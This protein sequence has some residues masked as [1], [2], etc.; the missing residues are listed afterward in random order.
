[1][2]SRKARFEAAKQATTKTPIW[3]LPAWPALTWQPQALAPGLAQ[4]HQAVL[5]LQALLAS[6][7]FE[8]VQGLNRDLWSQEAVATA[9]IEGQAL[10]WTAVRSSVG[11]RL[12]LAAPPAQDRA[13]EGLVQVMHDATHGHGRALTAQRLCAWQALLFP[14]NANSPPAM[15][16]ALGRFRTHAEPMQIISGAQGKEQV[17]YTAPPSNAVAQE[18]KRLLHWL[19]ATRPGKKLLVGMARPPSLVRAALVHLWFETIH[20]FEDGNGRVGRAMADYVLAQEFG[21]AHPVYSLSHQMRVER[22]DYYNALAQAQHAPQSGQGGIDVTPWVLWFVGVF[23]RGCQHSQRMVRASTDKAAF[24]QRASSES[25]QVLND[26]QRKLLQRLLDAGDGGFEGG[27][28]A[29]KYMAITSASKA[30]ATRDLAQLL[31]SGLLRVRGQGKATRYAVAVA[32][33]HLDYA[34]AKQTL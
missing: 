25:A 26:R 16:V 9:A 20:P 23:T 13:V 19:E 27:L 14:T 2:S 12:G 10:D 4:A 6:I 18:M 21:Q 17:H 5:D 30:T 11:H 34:L 29:D 31:A 28:S 7:G 15:Q 22:K 1:M 8:G 32:G 24:W 33:W 3:Q